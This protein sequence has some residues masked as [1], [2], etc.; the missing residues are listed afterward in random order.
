MNL[1][2][3]LCIRGGIDQLQC[4]LTAF[5]FLCSRYFF[6]VGGQTFLPVMWFSDVRY[7]CGSP[8]TW[9][10]GL[11][12]WERGEL[13]MCLLW[14]GY[15]IPK[16]QSPCKTFRWEC[17]TTS[18]QSTI[19]FYWTNRF[20]VV[21]CLYSNRSQMASKC[22]TKKKKGLQGAAECVTEILVIDFMFLFI[23]L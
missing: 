23:H 21:V 12:G 1:L 6:Q 4:K 18:F 8:D 7:R 22:G 2:H 13:Q 14:K 5:S 17:A 15:K 16:I 3:V 10:N 19:H 20:P 9:G 11:G